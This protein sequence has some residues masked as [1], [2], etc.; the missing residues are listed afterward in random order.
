VGDAADRWLR[1][2]WSAAA[3]G[4]D[5]GLALL[6]VG[7]LGRRMLLPASDLDLLVVSSGRR[8]V[9]QVAER[10]WYPIW[11]AGVALDHSV[12]TVRE[13]V[14]AADSDLRVALGLLDARLV[15]GDATVAADVVARRDRLWQT[16]RERWLPAV[17][18]AARDRHRDAGDV[19]F[20][21]EPDL[22][23]GRGGLRDV[24]LL[25]A[26]A[27][28]TPVLAP[29]V[30]APELEE[31]AA[32]LR[33]V[34]VA[35]QAPATGAAS[36]TRLL[37][38]DQDAVAARL[39]DADAD[40]LMG[41]VAAA[42]RA[43]AWA[44]DDGWERVTSW[45][46]GPRRRSAVDHPVGPG[47]VLRDGEIWLAATEPAA[48]PGLA[49]R[50]AVAAVDHGVAVARSTLD[51]LAAEAGPPPVPWPDDMRHALIR[52]LG[53]GPPALPVV[54][55]LDRR[56]L[57]VRLLPEWA[58]VRNRPQ[59]NAFHRFT[60]DRHLVETALA[61]APLLSAVDRP[62]L[63]VVG[64]LLHDIGKGAPGDHSEAGM[65]IAAAV[66]R[67]MGFPP[68]DVDVIARVVRHHLL[69]PD[70]A[71]RRDVDDPVT[72]ATV[73]VAV[74]DRLTLSLLAAL[75]AADGQATGPAAWGPWKQGLVDT[76]AARA[77]AHL[78]GGTAPPP[79]VRPTAEQ[80]EMLGARRLAV[81]G[82]G[83]RLTVVAPDRPGL[84][85]AVTGVL[86]LR[87]VDVRSATTGPGSGGMALLLFDV[88]PV[89]AALPDWD[90]VA[91]DVDAALSGRLPV[92]RRLAD[93]EA[94]ARRWRR[95]TAAG[96]PAV[97]V[98]AD[99]RASETATV[100]EVRAP[101]T[102]G[103]LSRIATALA[104]AGVSITA[105]RAATYGAG[106]VDAFYVVDAGGRPLDPGPPT[107]RVVAAVAAALTPG[108]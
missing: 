35:L 4:D 21:L 89:H 29:V 107:E 34:L 83:G 31:A 68:A 86:A 8:P 10:L 39:G 23:E 101:D 94:S 88:A 41:R 57:L 62:D 81:R 63:L 85:G 104:G 98:G 22:K 33:G 52:L 72:A 50:A 78:E 91:A 38:Q 6:A 93:H 49:L 61:T 75:A 30:G 2:L 73:A 16:R 67:R 53:S 95:R 99:H 55:A 71:T 74:G 103:L 100:I 12:R 47:L 70:T 15:A 26:V 106:V 102:P 76:L 54:E 40:G 20:L 3:G 92:A 65:E 60:V 17:M 87:G 45:L 97:E 27:A 80:E 108:L 9:P 43:V 25:T 77:A 84:L 79:D 18:E 96:T 36:R 42:G 58:H 7:G 64:A 13:V 11:D 37:L 59:R 19:A 105:A 44:S 32:A 66:A 82:A 69:L 56:G 51:R 46:A 24:T 90:S 5:R 48:D 14:A 1:S 28:V